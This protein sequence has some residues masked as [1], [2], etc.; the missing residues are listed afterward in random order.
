MYEY[1]FSTLSDKDLEVLV[2]DLLIQE[3]SIQ[4]QSFK[5]GKDKGIDLRYSTNSTENEIIVQVKHYLTS[6][7][8]LL[9]N[10]L[11]TKEKGKIEKLNPKRYILATSLSLSPL[12]KEK[13]KKELN[14]FVLNTNDIYGCDDLNSLLVKHSEIEKKHFKLWFSNINVLSKI[15][16]NGIDGRSAFIEQ[17]I[18]KNAGLFVVTKSYD[19]A[20]KILKNQRIL[21]IT[22]IPGIGKTTLANLIAYQLLS[23]DYRLVYIDE[24]I[25]DAEDMYDNDLKVKQ[26][27]F[28]DDFLGSSYLE[29][30]N[31]HGTDKSIVNFIERIKSSKNKYLILTTRSTILNQAKNHHERL[32]RANLDSI[33]YELEITDYSL[34]DKARILY[35]HLYFNDLDQEKLDEVFKN[36]NYW[37]IILH[38]N[39][40]PRLI[41]YITKDQN[42]NHLKTD[43]YIDFIITNLEHPEEIWASAFSNQLNNEEKFLLLTLLTFGKIIEKNTLEEAFDQRIGYEVS[44][45]GFTRNINIFNNSLRNLLDGYITNTIVNN[46]STYRFIDFI[47]PSLKDYLITFL[48]KNNSEKWRTI[49]SFKY[50]EQFLMIFRKK[51]DAENNVIIEPFE[52]RKF[53]EI[54]NAEKLQSIYCEDQNNI[55]IRLVKLFF[56]YRDDKNKDFVDNLVLVKLQLIDWKVV[57]IKFFEDLIPLLEKIEKYCEIYDYLKVNWDTIILKLIEIVDQDSEMAIIKK[58]FK[59]FDFD[60]DNYRIEEDVW[61]ENLFAAVDRIYNAE[62]EDI[63]NQKQSEIFSKSDFENLEQDVFDRYHDLSVDYLRGI[64]VDSSVDP[65]EGIDYKSIISDNQEA[66]EYAEAHQDDWK[67]GRHQFEDSSDKIDDLFSSL[68]K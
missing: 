42:T 12:D 8:K 6:G 1:N 39:Y 66:Q 51:G 29:I 33:K 43:D 47:N 52:I 59:K 58:L 3:L 62:A 17:K 68:E 7:Y 25:R 50:V 2:R 61:N 15:I 11:K 10:V 19:D 32:R 45:H 5:I 34:Y 60:Y 56:Y 57:K 46:L 26:L 54:A 65:F 30:I 18:K 21:L 49:E 14:P 24:R 44:R 53:L 63:I 4:F 48:N 35:N 64:E 20:I 23:Q 16:N 13:I 27:F 22:G 41:E 40:N 36:N 31:S 55:N 67:D 28:F 38:R 37:K 9:L